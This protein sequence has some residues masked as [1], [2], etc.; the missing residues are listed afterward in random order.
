MRGL[1]LIL[2]AV[3]SLILCGCVSVESVKPLSS[4]KSAVRDP[5]LAGLWS[6]KDDNG[7][8]GYLYI[9]FG[10]SG[11]GSI[12]LFGNDPKNGLVTLQRDFFVTHGAK[13][14][15]LNMSNQVTRVQHD[16]ESDKSGRYAF[17]VYEVLKSGELAYSEP[18]GDVFSK[19]VEAGKLR[20]ELTRDKKTNGVTDVL[21]TD[22]PE[23]ILAFVEA[24]PS[25]E[26][27]TPT[28]KFS[29]AGG[30]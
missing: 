11:T 29:R 6:F 1:S 27:A 2:L 3:T 13:R 9:A 15:Y 4:P 23:H 20:G 7:S 18:S 22:S 25:K 16:S 21:L 10:P 5:R 26:F 14:D 30:Q 17:A 8:P 24:L 12:L 28:L 19:A